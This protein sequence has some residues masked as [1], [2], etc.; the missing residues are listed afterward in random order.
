MVG[1]SVRCRQFVGRVDELVALE[2][3]RKSLAQSS[4]CFVLVSGEAG[5]GKTRLLC[6]FLER[7]DRR[8]AR[9]VVNTECLQ[10][11]QQ[12]LGPLR[13]F[14]R[15][16]VPG[17]ALDDLPDAVLGALVQIVPD[18]LP[19][20]IVEAHGASAL[21]KDRLFSAVLELLQSVCAKRATILTVEDLHWADESTLEFLGYVAR[22][23]TSMRLM[24]V[25]TC[26]SD[27]LAANENLLLALSP[28]LREPALRRVTLEPLAR[29]EIRALVD[30]AAVGRGRLPEA[31]VR[32]IERLSEGNPFFAEE[33]VSDYLDRAAVRDAPA[34]LPLS[35]RAS[36][37]AR[38]S[39]LSKAERNVIKHAAV[40]GQRFDPEA[41]AAVMQC[42]AQEVFPALRRA[43][44]L[45][46]LVDAGRG[47]LSC[48]F[49]HALT[50]QTIYDE[51]PAFEARELHARILR[52]FEADGSADD[53]LEEVAYHAWE[54]G[55]APKTLYYNERAANATFAMRALPEAVVCF[56]RAL[57][58]AVLPDDRARLLER[59]AVIERLQGHY[60]RAIDAF[61]SALAIR[62]ERREYDAAALLATSLLG[63]RYNVGDGSALEGARR[64]LR[65]FGSRLS[66]A[67]RNHLLVACA[68]VASAQIGVASAEPFVAAV[69]DPEHLQ[70]VV[71]KNFLIVALMRHAYFADSPAWRRTAADVDELL[72]ALKP[73]TVVEIESALALTGIYLGQNEIVERAIAR[74]DRVER[75]WGFRGLRLYGVAVEAAYRY[76]RG[77]LSEASS[78]IRDVL[79]NP[80]V[81]PAVMVALPIAACVAAASGD[82]TLWQRFDREH[83]RHA[84]ENPAEPDSVLVLGA[85]AGLLAARGGALEEARSDVRGALGSLEH[86]APEAMF[87][88][89]NAAGI[90]P[91]NEQHRVARL[92]HEAAGGGNDVAVATEALVLATQASRFGA[93]QHARRYGRSAAATYATL[94]WPL[95]E[96]RALEVAGDLAGAR[97]IYQR[98]GAWALA[99]R[100]GS[101]EAEKPSD[102]FGALSSRESEIVALL[103]LGLSNTEIAKNL[104][105]GSKTVEKHVSSVFGKLGLRSRS[106]VAALVA[107]AGN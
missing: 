35:I 52:T 50:R 59:I 107:S 30:G 73:E 86:A 104:N 62:L 79:A 28:L 67:A 57:E 38:L 103:A 98:C 41:L 71:R 21:E 11:A 99:R 80:D 46:L 7:L 44:E 47:R 24:I 53:R 18:R 12:P 54:S 56:E 1:E 34:Q 4:G 94:G 16:L 74:A 55:D 92:A 82:E 48:R 10:R 85:L 61:E 101:A 45:N 70:P 65:E 89:V 42:P 69:V 95:L 2:T 105:I 9:N 63:Q 5:I 68:R 37:A 78:R 26:R 91:E 72:R 88:L 83:V 6:E 49:R 22:R 25:A 87:V 93:A 15:A 13:A 77:E 29:L 106:Q 96:G 40:L 33:L 17:M 90:L 76:Q 27:E 19:A 58:A 60:Q 81:T 14:L 100:V 51:L 8:R 3:A 66:D 64:F 84:R 102:G 43:H 39:G 23:M 20:R 75:D 32:D 31:V 97:T 36:I